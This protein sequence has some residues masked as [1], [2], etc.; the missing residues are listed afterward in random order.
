MLFA[1][2]AGGI[3]GSFL[4]LMG[5]GGSII[6]VPALV[7]ILGLQTKAAIAT[8]LLVVGLASLVALLEHFKRRNVVFSVA[9]PFG[10]AGALG[11][12]AGARIGQ[13]IP[14][15]VQMLL[16][17]ILMCLVAI[18]M[19]KHRS[20]GNPQGRA[21]LSRG[22]AAALG[23]GFLSGVLTGVLGVGGGFIIVPILSLLL[24]LP[25]LEAIGTSLL[26]IAINSLAGLLAYI[27]F[28]HLDVST[29]TFGVATVLFSAMASL[30]A[31]HIPQNQLKIS[32]ALSLIF[33]SV[34]M[35]LNRSLI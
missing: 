32:F 24:N 34:F 31:R 4:G 25:M 9:A 29:A 3:T 30:I 28:L 26:I 19:L 15:H 7:Y 6:A 27:H 23:A 5:G 35:L 13:A 10:A 20:Q 1:L 14:D 33:L 22:K 11:A 2:I 17:A 18:L 16:L 21:R 12:I 8:S